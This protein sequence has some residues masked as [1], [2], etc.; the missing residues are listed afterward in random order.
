MDHE[1]QGIL[2]HKRDLRPILGRFPFLLPP[3]RSICVLASGCF[4]PWLRFLLKEILN[5]L[6]SVNH[7]GHPFEIGRT[8]PLLSAFLY[9]YGGLLPDVPCTP[10]S[11]L[12]SY[13]FTVL[14]IIFQL[15]LSLCTA[16]PGP[17]SLISSLLAGNAAFRS[18]SLSST[19][20]FW[21]HMVLKVGPAT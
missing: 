17:N 12:S 8:P 10:G 13:V 2:L 15:P 20:S 5:L 14:S 9:I 18:L 4:I 21:V 7:P 19:L 11:S 3:L 6:L 16:T 1:L